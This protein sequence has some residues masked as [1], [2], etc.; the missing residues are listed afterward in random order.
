M[1]FAKMKNMIR[2]NRL[3][4]YFAIAFIW[5]WGWWAGLI[6]S[7]PS[8]AILTGNLPPSFIFFALLGGFGPSLSG[9]LVSLLANG[10]HEVKETLAGLKSVRFSLVWYAA[11]LLTVPLLIVAQTGLQAVTGRSVTFEVSGLMLI[12]GF[13]WPLFSSFGEEIGW[14]GF[15]LPKLQKRYG[16]R[17]ASLILGLVWGLWHLPSDYI[18]YSSYGWL[19]IPLFILIGPIT[20]TAHSVIMTLIYNK[21]KG[22]L[23][24]M[25]IYH[26]TITFTSILAPAIS[27]SGHVDDLAKT[28]VSVSVLCILAILVMA[29]SKTMRGKSVMTKA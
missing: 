3:K 29:F 21:T 25:I 27:F 8:D 10:K 22:S 6:F 4:V 14:R 13:I 9:I 16:I 17:S 11:S 18:A 24:A 15:A 5:S 1:R 2:N 19:F 7:T 26:F 20:L 12:M 23:V 28:A